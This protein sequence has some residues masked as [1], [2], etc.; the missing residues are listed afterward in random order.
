MIPEPFEDP[1]RAVVTGLWWQTL[2]TRSAVPN[3][4]RRLLN[5]IPAV[6]CAAAFLKWIQYLGNPSESSPLHILQILV[7]LFVAAWFLVGIYQQ[8][9]RLVA[10]LCF[11]CF[12]LYSTYSAAAGVSSCG[13]FGDLTVSPWITL[14][15]DLIATIGLISWQPTLEGAPA[16]SSRGKRGAIV[17][18]MLLSGVLFLAPLNK[19]VRISLTRLWDSSGRETVF[20]DPEEWLGKQFPFLDL[21]EIR[22]DLKVGTWLLVLHRHDCHKCRAFL[23]DLAQA[24]AGEESRFRLP[25][26]AGVAVIEIPPYGNASENSRIARDPRIEERAGMQDKWTSGRLSAKYVWRGPVPHIFLMRN[27]TVWQV[28]SPVTGNP[29]EAMLK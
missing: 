12:S 13:C 29:P 27:G 7:E 2:M 15:F 6:L 5:T 4:Q 10:I 11:I 19:S 23:N 17:L 16:C 24:I 20:L 8:Q 26:G 1:P 3:L 22:Q 21:V 14:A 28:L 18:V 25:A 9:L